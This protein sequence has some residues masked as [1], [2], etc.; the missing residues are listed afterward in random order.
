M[1]IT[2]LS[3]SIA[4]MLFAQALT[5]LAFWLATRRKQPP[6]ARPVADGGAGPETMAD[7]RP[8]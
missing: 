6:S 4:P 7:H 1:T 8:R 5:F 2:Q 3:L